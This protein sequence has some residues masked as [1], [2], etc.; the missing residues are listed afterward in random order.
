MSP[1]IVAIMS[2]RRE[3]LKT[4]PLAAAGVMIGIPFAPLSPEKKTSSIFEVHIDP[5][6]SDDRKKFYKTTVSELEQTISKF[7]NDLLKVVESKPAKIVVFNN[8]SFQQQ[9]SPKDSIARK[10]FEENP[11]YPNTGLDDSVWANENSKRWLA[12][13]KVTQEIY[14]AGEVFRVYQARLRADMNQP[15]VFEGR[16]EI[17]DWLLYGSPLSW[18]AACF[19]DG[20]SAVDESEAYFN[21]TTISPSEIHTPSSLFTLGKGLDDTQAALNG[22]LYVV[23]KLIQDHGNN[24]HSLLLKYYQL[25]GAGVDQ[26][27]AF[28]NLFKISERDFEKE[29]QKKP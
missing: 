23:E 10:F 1:Y 11:D 5:T 26:E 25:V 19:P 2:S 6:I 3:F 15:G 22:T 13:P 20:S 29:L 14:I 8:L 9:F 7:P 12:Y 24:D 27:K 17:P 4:I 18:G 16:F 21:Q 28:Q